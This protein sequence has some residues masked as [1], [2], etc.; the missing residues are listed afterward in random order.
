MRARGAALIYP[1]R[2]RCMTCRSFFG[3]TIL[4]GLWCSYECAGHPEP[5][6]DPE[7]WPRQHRLHWRVGRQA[8]KVYDSEQ[9][10]TR[11]G[12]LPEPLNAYLCDYC[13]TW[14]IGRKPRDGQGEV[15]GQ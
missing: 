15:A 12:R 9:E 7:D 4:A 6:K 10:A 11:S 2:K 3:F 1:E 14:H 13:L 5:S 8:K